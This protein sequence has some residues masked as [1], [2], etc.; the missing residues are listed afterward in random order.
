VVAALGI[1]LAL[2][3]AWR[4]DITQVP[5][6]IEDLRSGTIEKRDRA[7]RQLR[8]MGKPAMPFLEA[9][10]KE[11]DLEVAARAKYLIRYIELDALISAGLRKAIPNIQDRLASGDAHLWTETFLHVAG[12]P[13]EKRNF[14]ELTAS[15][16]DPLVAPAVSAAASTAERIQVVQSGLSWRLPSL[17][18]EAAQLL[19]REPNTTLRQVC[20]R[21]LSELD[22]RASAPLIAE[23]AL[24]DDPPARRTAVRAL[25][26]LGHSAAMPVLRRALGDKAAV[27]RTRALLALGQLEVRDAAGDVAP[28]LKD[29]NYQVRAMA[30]TALGQIRATASADEVAALLK[31]KT[32]AARGEAALALAA[33][34]EVR[35]TPDLAALLGD[36]DIAVREKAIRALAALGS[37]DLEK[38][39]PQLLADPEPAIR[40]AA[41]FAVA[42]LEA[43]DRVADVVKK[44][45]DLDVEV[46]IAAVD[47]L[48][49][50]RADVSGL[51]RQM[52]DADEL[53]R[54]RA[55]TALCGAGSKAAAGWLIDRGFMPLSLNQ[56]RKRSEWAALQEPAAEMS[57]EGSPREILERFA[58]SSGWVLVWPEDLP[59]DDYW[60]AESVR[61]AGAPSP[62]RRIDSLERICNGSY[63][64]GPY[65]VILEEGK[66]RVVN[67]AAAA[68]FWKA[69]WAEFRDKK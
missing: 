29:P 67:A 5:G 31:D 11:K 3:P 46:R 50:L 53:V 22:H 27:V 40:C 21:A 64:A 63:A 33:L 32:P 18:A 20:V 51:D 17:A 15:D 41:V 58:A 44:L 9:A 42:A 39:L 23:M 6:L 2:L 26:L 30:A 13:R 16:L 59:R 56:F 4:Q 65:T 8:E 38:K 48:S 54:I 7:I 61:V 19:G 45:A 62:K 60:T 36:P 24:E 1:L 49:A 69:W 55:A 43:R 12:G 10:A 34:G 25:R 66:L 68:A 57:W 47:C 35:R 37:R 52:Q 28:L 14:P